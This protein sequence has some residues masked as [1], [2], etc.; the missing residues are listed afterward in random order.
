[1]KKWI[2]LAV[3]FSAIPFGFAQLRTFNFEQIDSLQAI[4]KRKIIVFMHTDWCKFCHVMKNTTFKDQELIEELNSNF[5]FVSF[6]AEENQKIIF[7]NRVFDFKSSGN[8][9]GIHELAIELGTINNQVSY[10]IL[11]VL[12]DKNE[13]IFQRNTFLNAKEFKKILTILKQ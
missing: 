2:F 8:N 3:F 13:I 12:N 11:C 5:Y 6:D 1:M 4:Q 10:P 7:N 9:S